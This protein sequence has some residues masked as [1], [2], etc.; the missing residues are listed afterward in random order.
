MQTCTPRCEGRAAL[1]GLELGEAHAA[2]RQLCTSHPCQHETPAPPSKGDGDQTRQDD[3]YAVRD[4]HAEVMKDGVSGFR[5]GVAFSLQAVD[6][7]T[8][9]KT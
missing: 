9:E 5:G 1:P 3:Q 8:S 4:D 2:E 6:L 7:L